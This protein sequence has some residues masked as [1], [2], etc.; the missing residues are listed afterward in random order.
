MRTRNEMSAK[1]ASCQF[2]TYFKI[3]R[4]QAR[5]GAWSDVKGA[6]PTEDDARTNAA[7]FDGQTRIREVSMKGTRIL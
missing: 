4:Y 3:Q 2:A 6:F 1:R 5:I 7:R